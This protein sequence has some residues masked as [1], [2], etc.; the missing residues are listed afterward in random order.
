[1]RDPLFG[2]LRSLVGGAQRNKLLRSYIRMTVEQNE[3]KSHSI[4]STK[5]NLL[6]TPCTS[7]DIFSIHNDESHQSMVK[8]TKA[9]RSLIVG[10]SISS[11]LFWLDYPDSCSFSSHFLV[12]IVGTIVL[13]KLIELLLL[14]HLDY[15]VSQMS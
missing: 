9:E 10:F 8:A 15:C 7:F 6:R 12:E 11:A 2:D 14:T 13:R 5:R 1:M 3:L 4:Y